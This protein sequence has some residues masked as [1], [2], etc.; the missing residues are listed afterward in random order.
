MA[1]TGY[2][3]TADCGDIGD[4]RTRRH[5]RRNHAFQHLCRDDD[6]LAC[7]SCLARDLLL[8][9]RHALDRHLNTKIA[10]RHH[11]R[12]AGDYDGIKIVDS[13]RLLDLHDDRRTIAD[14]LLGFQHVLGA[15]HER[16][17]DPV[18]PDL[19][20]TIEVGMILFR[21]RRDRQ[22]RIGQTDALAAGQRAARDHLGLDATVAGLLH[23]HADLAVVEQQHIALGDG[24]ENLR[25]WQVP[26]RGGTRRRIKVEDE[27]R[28]VIHEHPPAVEFAEP[29]LRPLQVAQHAD[30]VTVF[31]G[32]RADGLGVGARGF[33]RRVA[34]IDAE[35]VDARQHEA[36]HHFRSR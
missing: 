6:G 11:E 16:E 18:R 13:R 7:R 28:A 25:M 9:T 21:Q 33:V 12:V 10:A 32:H 3:P 1:S 8:Q 26:A 22:Q 14:D 17:R 30:G 23:A 29:E 24:V 15:L 34:H 35:H 36:F 4:L 31:L 19:E 27:R 20:R 2:W 5:G